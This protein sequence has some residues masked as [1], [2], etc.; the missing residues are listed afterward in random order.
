MTFKSTVR[1]LSRGLGKM[2][3][4]IALASLSIGMGVWLWL[5]IVSVVIGLGCLWAYP[6][7]EPDGELKPKVNESN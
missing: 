1:V 3:A 6:W 7:S 4:I 5:M 2:A